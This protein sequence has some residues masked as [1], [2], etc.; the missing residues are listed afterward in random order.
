MCS[1]C[2]VALSDNLSFLPA[3]MIF[4]MRLFQTGI[5][6]EL[7]LVLNY[8]SPFQSIVL[9]SAVS[10]PPGH[11]LETKFLRPHIGP[12]ESQ[13]LSEITLS[14]LL[15]QVLHMILMHAEV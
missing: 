6:L 5:Y 1:I 7:S 11:L 4:C 3:F 10:V 14:N 8:T 12:V 2:Y 15:K 13:T 9:R